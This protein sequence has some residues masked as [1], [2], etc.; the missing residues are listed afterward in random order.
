MGKILD[1]KAEKYYGRCI[2]CGV[3]CDEENLKQHSEEGHEVIITKFPDKTRPKIR[4]WWAAKKV[5]E[6]YG[7]KIW[8]PEK[9]ERE[10][11]EN[12]LP[13]DAIIIDYVPKF[14]D[15]NNP[16]NEE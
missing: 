8:K 10:V 6:K 7:M 2:R 15:L 4:K 1:D 14:V 9:K 16:E 3:N 5:G 12:T 13:D 11:S